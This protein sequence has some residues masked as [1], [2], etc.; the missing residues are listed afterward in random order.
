MNRYHVRIRT[1]TIPDYWYQNQLHVKYRKRT[2]SSHNEEK[3]K[4]LDLNHSEVN[5]TSI[6]G[7]N[8]I[9][10]GYGKMF[11]TA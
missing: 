10:I 9:N 5:T 6:E 3:K 4:T 8:R 1:C 2:I 7:K 11:S